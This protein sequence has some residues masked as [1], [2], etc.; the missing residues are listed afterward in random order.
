MVPEAPVTSRR[1]S[2]LASPILRAV[3]EAVP[4]PLAVVDHAGTLAIANAA[5]RTLAS[6]TATFGDLGTLVNAADLVGAPY[7][8]RLSALE[9]PLALAGRRLARA[10]QDAVAG[11]PGDAHVAYRARRPDGE[12]PYEALVVPVEGVRAALVAHGD[13]GERE[14]AA[15]AEAAAVRLGL[16]A[17]GLRS[18]ERH[19]S[20]RLAT[21]GRELHMPITP[22]RLE[23]HLLLNGSLGPLTDKQRH[24]LEVVARNVQRWADGEAAFLQGP[25]ESGP[26]EF[27]LAALVREATDGRQTQA[28]QQGVTL[29]ARLPHPLPVRA[30]P[31]DVHE[32]IDR[33]LDRA[34]EATSSGAAVDVEARAA[35]GEALVEVRDSGAGWSARE[36]KSAFE[37]WAGRTPRADGPGLSL[38]FARHLVQAQGGRTWAESDGVGQG[39]LLGFALPL[40][41][42]RN[43]RR[44]GLAHDSSVPASP[45]ERFVH[46]AR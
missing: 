34:L 13:L 31:E 38:P 16:E 7:V 42:G 4:T 40:I 12:T 44:E 8:R 24:A 45:G 39:V 20:R 46:G 5:W 27:D 26:R 10:I 30:L 3:L 6:R 18:R 9:G 17:E 32:V 37:P 19:S 33:F 22:V 36:V 28:L 35:D 29:T 14:H 21:I 43:P 25:E 15:E 41:S 23:L 2:D 11:R 1:S